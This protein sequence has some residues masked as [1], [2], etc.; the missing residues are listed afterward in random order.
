MPPIP[1]ISCV[2]I[3]VAALSLGTSAAN[4]VYIRVACFRTLIVTRTVTLVAEDGFRPRLSGPRDRWPRF[5]LFLVAGFE[6]T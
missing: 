1:S 5:S 4:W 2:L 6:G 3:L